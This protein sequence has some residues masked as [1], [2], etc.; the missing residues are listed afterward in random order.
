MSSFGDKLTPITILI[1]AAF[2]MLITIMDR[3]VLAIGHID[4]GLFFKVCIVMVV[5]ALVSYVVSDV[6][7]V[8][9]SRETCYKVFTARYAPRTMILNDVNKFARILGSLS[10]RRDIVL[11]RYIIRGRN[12]TL[13]IKHRGSQPVELLASLV[14]TYTRTINIVPENTK[15][16]LQKFNDSTDLVAKLS[17][18]LS[19]L[20]NTIIVNLSIFTISASSK[21]SDRLIHIDLGDE[22][23]YARK[24][25]KLIKAINKLNN[26]EY[27]IVVV[28][29]DRQVAELFAEALLERIRVNEC[30]I[31]YS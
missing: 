5:I 6:N 30:Y 17:S 12:A 26:F 18:I 19:K 20:S 1:F 9:S 31:L 3:A 8:M 4:A 2:Y 24:M 11:L 23:L 7:K 14:S 27:N 13:C 21:G 29:V 15:C 28:G 22:P 16:I 25:E 10:K